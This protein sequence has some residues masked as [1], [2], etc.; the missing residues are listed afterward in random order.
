[1][2]MNLLPWS[3]TTPEGFTLRGWH[4]PP[5]G[6][7]VIH[8]LHGNSFSGQVYGPM[9][10]RLSH[11][12]DLWLSD[13]QGHGESDH[14]GAFVG[15]NRSAELAVAAFKH[16]LPMYEGVPRYALGHSLGG[17]LTT[18]AM[19]ADAKLFQRAVLL[20]PM[21]FARHL[22][23]LFPLLSWTG[24]VR[25][26]GPAA[27]ASRRRPH[28]PSAEAAHKALHNRGTYKGW[29]DE[30]FAA[31]ITHGFKPHADGG[32]AL[33]CLPSREA[34]VF[35]SMPRGL[36]KSMLR[37]ATPTLVVQAAEPPKMVGRNV[38]NWAARNQHVTVTRAA[39]GHCF[40][41]EDPEAAARAVVGWLRA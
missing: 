15:W 1:M 22:L 30:A 3:F 19:G 4:T 12:F 32:V 37:V 35:S 20:D 25:R 26:A 40:M 39:G 17:V 33:K 29:T 13:I 8:F 6:K 23:M 41:Q 2:T 27:R 24:V 18:L 5:S 16:H 36:W 31:F 9:L 38:Q 11:D 10:E 14:G 7:P 21:L 34:D 28:W